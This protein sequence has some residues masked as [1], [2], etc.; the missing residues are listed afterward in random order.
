MFGKLLG[1]AGQ[2]SPFLSVWLP[3]FIFLFSGIIFLLGAKK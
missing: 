1:I 3:N 2:L